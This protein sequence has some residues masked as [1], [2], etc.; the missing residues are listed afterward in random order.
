MHEDNGNFV[1]AFDFFKKWA[2]ISEI[3]LGPNHPKT[4]RAK[5][6]LKE[7]RY[8]FIEQRLK[9]MEEQGSGGG[10]DSAQ[11]ITEGVI[12]REARRLEDGNN[13]NSDSENHYDEEGDLDTFESEDSDEEGDRPP[14]SLDLDTT[15][16]QIRAFSSLLQRAIGDISGPSVEPE[17]IQ[18]LINSINGIG[19]AG[20]G[21][22]SSSNRGDEEGT[23]SGNDLSNDIDGAMSEAMAGF[24]DDSSHESHESSREENS[25]DYVGLWTDDIVSPEEGEEEVDVVSIDNL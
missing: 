1:K 15:T 9:E 18:N 23:T 13:C 22:G 24:M 14:A 2:A 17:L 25:Q 4:M 19:G 6:V 12:N 5:G 16:G 21:G 7:T 20:G 10:N 3:V 8:R 11:L